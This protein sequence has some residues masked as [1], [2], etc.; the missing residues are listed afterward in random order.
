[1]LKLNDKSLLVERCL[2]NGEWI[3]RP[4]EPVVNPATGETI[5]SVPNLGADEAELAVSAAQ[6]AFPRWTGLTAKQRA[7]TL[8]KWF[9]L[10]IENKDDIAV[11]LTA[12]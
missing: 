9:D 1:M 11:L 2:V 12:E 6:A 4:T 3:G 7:G 8:R 5:A 10:I